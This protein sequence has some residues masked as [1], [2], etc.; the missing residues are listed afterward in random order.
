M[1]GRRS[2]LPG[3]YPSALGCS[4]INFST[5]LMIDAAVVVTQPVC[6]D[7][8]RR[9]PRDIQFKC[10]DTSDRREYEQVGFGR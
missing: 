7:V 5:V 2:D 8:E 1:D 3:Q 9:C 6:Y 10:P 4:H